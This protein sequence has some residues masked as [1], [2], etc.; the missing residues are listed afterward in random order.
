MALK[1][2][3]FEFP[4]HGYRRL[5]PFNRLFVERI[6]SLVV[7]HFGL[8]NNSGQLLDR[9]STGIYQLELDG[10]KE[11]LMDYL[12]KVGS[13]GD[14]PPVW[15]PPPSQSPVEVFNHIGVTSNLH[16]A[17]TSLNNVA[18]RVVNEL[19]RTTGGTIPIDPIALLRSTQE[20]QKHLIKELFPKV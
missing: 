18:V 13:L 8:L 2:V 14:P 17:E 6:D 12:G 19:R 3:Q 4:R 11:S 9:Y 5:M 16:V 10:Q 15:Q 20:I 7:L 1:N